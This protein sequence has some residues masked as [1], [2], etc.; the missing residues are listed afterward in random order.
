MS[1]VL[2]KKQP[3]M[4]LPIIVITFATRENGASTFK[5]RIIESAMTHTSMASW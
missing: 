3:R 1:I 5:L 4:P 2:A